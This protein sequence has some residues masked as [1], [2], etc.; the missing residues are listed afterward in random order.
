MGRN[1]LGLQFHPEVTAAG[2]ERWYIG[3]A[4]EIAGAPGV[5]VD[6][7][8]AESER[9]APALKR[10][11]VRFLREWLEQTAPAAIA[12]KVVE[13]TSPVAGK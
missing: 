3:H 10:F 1:V 7:L 12:D 5:R 2:L 11:A 8:R 9:L 4:C 13:S 6:A